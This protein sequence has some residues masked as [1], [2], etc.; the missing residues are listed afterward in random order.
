MTS[1]DF[2]TPRLPHLLRLPEVL[3]LVGV[4]RSTLYAMVQ[5]GEFP[6]PV[7]I[8]VRAVAWRAHEVYSWV[9]T[10]PSARAPMQGGTK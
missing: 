1:H 10:R 6:P 2:Q 8:G 3:A 5:R 4:S 9:E 7:R